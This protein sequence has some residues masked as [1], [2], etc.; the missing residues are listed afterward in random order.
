MPPE[1]GPIMQDAGVIE[2]MVAVVIAVL[3]VLAGLLG[4]GAK[5]L[6]DL[7]KTTA[8]TKD[9]VT[10]NHD[11]NLRDDLTEVRDLVQAGFRRMDHQFGEIHDQVQREARDRQALDDRAQEEHKRIWKAIE[12][13]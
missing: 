11:S 2:A 8:I 7:Q 10:N 9:Q 4:L 6:R 5:K 3:A 12:K 1:L 13:N